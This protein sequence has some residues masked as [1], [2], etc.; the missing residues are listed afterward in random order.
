MKLNIKATNIDLT[1]EIKEYLEKKIGSVEK[2]LNKKDIEI[3]S[4]EAQVEIGLPS[5]HH[6]KGDIYY[7]EVN[8]QLPKKLIRVT[9]QKD[10]LKKAIVKVKNK[11]KREIK[12]Y[13]HK[14][15]S[16]RIKEWLKINK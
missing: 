1:S 16:Q 2:F 11:L 7:A 13:Y 4:V 6:Q 8:L 14:P 12:K 10:D 15:I 5:Q 9:A 3:N